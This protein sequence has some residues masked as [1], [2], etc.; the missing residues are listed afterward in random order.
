MSQGASL[1]AE[2]DDATEA[3][4][5]KNTPDEEETLPA[6]GV[7]SSE[8]RELR[9]AASGQDAAGQPDA[10]LRPAQDGDA[11]KS[12]DGGPEEDQV[13]GATRDLLASDRRPVTAAC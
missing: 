10:G 8:Q 1:D 3:V 4:V 5:G 9:G 12:M 13:S 6:G 11:T 2:M 7:L